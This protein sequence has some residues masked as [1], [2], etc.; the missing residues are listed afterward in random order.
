VYADWLEE[1][2]AHDVAAGY[3]L[4]GGQPGASEPATQRRIGLLVTTAAAMLL[5]LPGWTSA[6]AVDRPRDVGWEPTGP[7]R[8][9]RDIRFDADGAVIGD[10]PALDGPGEAGIEGAVRRYLA[11]LRDPGDTRALVD[12]LA[13]ARACAPAGFDRLVD[14][15]LRSER[16]SAAREIALALG[17]EIT[18]ADV[19]VDLPLPG[20]SGTFRFNS[21]PITNSTQ[22]VSGSYWRAPPGTGPRT[23]FSAL[24]ALEECGEEAYTELPLGERVSCINEDIL[25]SLFADRPADGPLWT[26]VDAVQMLWWFHECL[27]ANEGQPIWFDEGPEALLDVLASLGPYVGGAETPAAQFPYTFLAFRDAI[28]VSNLTY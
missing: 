7:L 5:D 6:E 18:E 28:L 17:E 10:V 24:C 12:A 21:V 15:L 8:A 19:T 3:R 16:P 11:F 27:G 14:L 1:H 13:L 25:W 20:E 23:A 4:L 26:P 2:G 22:G 9:L